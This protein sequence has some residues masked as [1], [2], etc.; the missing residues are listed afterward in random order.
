MLDDD[1]Y[2][3]TKLEIFVKICFFIALISTLLLAPL[4]EG[5]GISISML[6]AGYLVWIKCDIQ[7][8]SKQKK[9]KS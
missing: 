9:G 4:T 6:V 2:E 1:Y 8:Y 3:V 7:T 5:W